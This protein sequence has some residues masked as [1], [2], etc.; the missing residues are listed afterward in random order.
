MDGGP[1]RVAG[2]AGIVKFKLEITCDNSAFDAA[3]CTETARILSE[4]ARKIRGAD[5]EDASGIGFSLMDLN[6]NKVG[7]A[8]FIDD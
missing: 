4:A 5:E 6:G 7:R 1:D 8:E 3:L 2:K